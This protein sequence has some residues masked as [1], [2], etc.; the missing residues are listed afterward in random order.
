MWQVFNHI[1]VSK[2]YKTRLWSLR[3]SLSSHCSCQQEAVELI[4]A[5]LASS[6]PINRFL[7]GTVWAVS[8]A[9][10]SKQP[11]FSGN[12]LHSLWR[13]IS[14]LKLSLF[15]LCGP[16]SETPAALKDW[17]F[18]SGRP[19]K[20]PQRSTR[21]NR[22]M[23]MNKCW[24]VKGCFSDTSWFYCSC[25]FDLFLLAVTGLLDSDKPQRWKLRWQSRY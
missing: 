20:G 12:I 11:L 23:E 3:N 17:S 25:L 2:F 19:G 21:W 14:S 4:V 5:A 9:K 22:N 24:G 18:L 16:Q 15:L 10:C 6:Q 13:Q 8:G 7:Y 1:S